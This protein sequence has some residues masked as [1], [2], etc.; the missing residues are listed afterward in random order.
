MWDRKAK[1]RDFERYPQKTKARIGLELFLGYI[2]AKPD[3][4]D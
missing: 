3:N 4:S 1:K 2:T